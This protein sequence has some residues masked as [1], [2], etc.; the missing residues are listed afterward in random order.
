MESTFWRLPVR[1]FI[2]QRLMSDDNP[3]GDLTINNMELSA[4]LAHLH[5]FAPLMVP[6]EHISTKVDNTAADSWERRGSVSSAT[7]VGPLLR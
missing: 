6:L 4:Y 3:T 5:I 2:Y 1:N 7:A